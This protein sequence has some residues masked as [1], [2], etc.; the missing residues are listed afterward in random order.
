MSE[1]TSASFNARFQPLYYKLRAGRTALLLVGLLV[2]LG[3]ELLA[4]TVSVTEFALVG[5]PGDHITDAFVILNG[6]TQVVDVEIEIVDW[7]RALDGITRTY[8]TGTLERSCSSWMSL[9]SVTAMLAPDA[10]IEIPLDIRVPE[11]VQGT[12]WTG[13]LIS[14]SVAGGSVEE[15]DI[16]LSRQFLVR[17][18]VTVSPTTPNGRVS[19]L[20]VLGVNPLGIE[21][22]FAN[23]GDTFL[24]DVSGLIAVESSAGVTLFEIPLIPFDV[25]PGYVLRQS[26]RGNWGLQAT[27]MYLIRAVLDFGAEYLVAGQSVLRIDELHLTAIGTA[28]FPPTDLNGDGLY[29]DV[30]GD[31]TLTVADADLLEGFIDTPPV[32]DNARAFDFSNDGDV[33]TA[34]VKVLRDTVLRA[35]E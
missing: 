25:L 2:T 4:V 8:D 24:S 30:N 16:R 1:T 12:Y 35:I 7:D 15:G 17:V 6:E 10:E 19:N 11:A 33:T 31:G 3:I 26:V 27:G 23:T 18:F 14:A 13:I 9:S 22:E 5:N 28:N 20:Q 29:E 21:V 32:Q 34:D